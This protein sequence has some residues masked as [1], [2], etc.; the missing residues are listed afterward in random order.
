MK[1]IRNELLLREYAKARELINA[2]PTEVLVNRE[3]T[4]LHLAA[5]MP[6]DGTNVRMVI[7]EGFGHLITTSASARDYDTPLQVAVK[8]GN[9]YGVRALLAPDLVELVEQEVADVCLVLA[10]TYGQHYI[11]VDL[12]Q[13]LRPSAVAAEQALIVAVRES[14]PDT[15]KKLFEF[16]PAATVKI[17]HTLLELMMA[18]KKNREEL[19]DFIM[20]VLD[21]HPELVN[22]PS[23]SK[24]RTPLHIVCAAKNKVAVCFVED[25]IERGADMSL[26]DSANKTP[27]HVAFERNN[28]ECLQAMLLE[29]NAPI[30][31][32]PHTRIPSLYQRIVR[33]GSQRMVE[34]MCAGRPSLKHKQRFIEDVMVAGRL[35]LFM[36]VIREYS[37]IIRSICKKTGRTILCAAIAM[38]VREEY[39]DALLACPRIDV[40][41][42]DH[43]GNTALHYAA[44]SGRVHTIPK[45][46]AREVLSSL[47][48]NVDGRLP[49][50]C[51]PFLCPDVHR[52]MMLAHR[53]V[54]RRAKSDTLAFFIQHSTPELIARLRRPPTMQEVMRDAERAFR[55]RCR[56]TASRH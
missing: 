54:V 45:L 9:I 16:Y 56:Y 4:V 11:V 37:G 17:F 3:D 15:A 12:V 48:R 20:D 53:E 27:L 38:N 28:E 55:S 36:F 7:E 10:A 22:A 50:D 52:S 8:R 43:G 41:V 29:K 39:V 23:H 6:D 21:K 1:A 46:L 30:D 35:P 34:A 25:L 24:L 33:G 40:D 14:H 44:Y 26:A 2:T 13:R 5:S 49:A 32:T 42:P 47:L 19:E 18:R 51:G 31:W